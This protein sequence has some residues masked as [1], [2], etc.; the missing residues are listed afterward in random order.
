MTACFSEWTSSCKA[1]N[2]QNCV[3]DDVLKDG[4]PVGFQLVSEASVLLVGGKGVLH[5]LVIP[6]DTTPGTYVLEVF[7]GVSELFQL[8]ESEEERA[9]DLQGSSMSPRLVDNM[10]ACCCVAPRACSSKSTYKLIVE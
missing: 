5:E 8:R 2:E 1:R 9:N 7:D 6:T 3:E 4:L 10:E